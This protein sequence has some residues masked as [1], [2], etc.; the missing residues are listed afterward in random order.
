MKKFNK[1]L[2]VF[3]LPLFAMVLVSGALL[4]Y[5]GF[6]SQT[7]TVNQPISVSDATDEFNC[8]AGQTCRGDSF[9]IFNDGSSEREV[10]ITSDATEGEI[11]V[12]YI[13]ELTLTEKTVDFSE[14]VWEIPTDAEEVDVEY[15]AINGE[16][17]AEVGDNAKEGYV[18]IY[19]KDNSDRFSSPAKAILV[20]D[21]VGNLA[22]A[23][24]KNNDEYDYC[25]TGEY[26]T[27]H[28][29]KIWY[30]PSDAINVDDTLDWSRANEFYYETELIQFS[31]DGVLTIYPGSS[32]TLIPEYTLNSLLDE[33]SNPY[34][35]STT[36]NPVA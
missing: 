25:D 23:D 20:E 31:V 4:T 22:Y 33:G 12:A 13:G 15:I 2:L 26:S 14:D 30:V 16:F 3:G 10:E 1:K 6:F 7:I 17:S 28:G 8:E 11:D 27:C 18:L 5:Y 34:I 36:V 24:D 29:A 35:V 19:Y 9:T 21:V 32:L